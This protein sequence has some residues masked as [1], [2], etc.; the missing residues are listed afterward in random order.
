[1]RI[2]RPNSEKAKK[3]VVIIP[4]TLAQGAVLSDFSLGLTYDD[5]LL[6]PRRSRVSS[7]QDI[8]TT[9]RLTRDL[10]LALP[11]L[12][13]NMDTVTEAPMAIGMAREGGVGIIHRFMTIDEEASQVAQVKRPEEYVRRELHTITP[14]RT[15]REASS[16]MTHVDVTSLLVVDRANSLLG[17]LTARDLLF[18]DDFG[19][20]VADRMTAGE[21]LV[22]APVGTSLEEARG[23]LHE[24]RLEKLPLVDS[25]GHLRGLVTARDILRVIEHPQSARDPQGRLLVGAAIGAVGDYQERAEALLA[26]GADVLVI[27]IAHGHSDHALQATR[28]VRQAF[29]QAQLIAGNVATADGTRDLIEAGADGVK[30]GVGPGSACTTRMVAGAGVPQLT[31]VLDCAAEANRSGVPI[32]ADGGI[33]GAGD[34]A[35]ALAAGAASVMIGYLLA[36]TEESPGE[37]VVRGGARYKVYRGSASAGAAAARR[38]REQG[39]EPLDLLDELAAGVVPEGVESV[40]PHKGPLA[41]VLYQLV[42]G[43]RS[44]MSYA[45]ACTLAE[46]RE[47]ARFIRQSQAAWREGLPHGLNEQ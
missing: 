11:I 10:S 39:D 3:A 9:S 43:L 7:R 1:L 17:I 30:V 20:T 18:V 32:I 47:N 8:D 33:R 25:E 36:G 23:I 12:S 42:G 46:L 35:K 29:P 40:V 37:T 19:R 16:L 38:E 15:L 44:G 6:V 28:R 45:N 24:H 5:V 34:I 2:S 21:Q 14:D 27:D 41:D 31:A 26:A 13:A 4:L 22:T